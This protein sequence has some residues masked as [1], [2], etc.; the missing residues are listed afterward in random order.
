MKNRKGGSLL[1][2]FLH[3]MQMI[4]KDYPYAPVVIFLYSLSG[5]AIPYW[6]LYYSARILSALL[7]GIY[8][9]AIIQ[10]ILLIGGTVVWGIMFKVAQTYKHIYQWTLDE[11]LSNQ[12]TD[13]AFLMEYDVFES[14]ESMDRLHTIYNK[15]AYNGGMNGIWWGINECAKEAF[16]TLFASIFFI[17]LIWMDMQN[18]SATNMLIVVVLLLLVAFVIFCVISTRINYDRYEKIK[19]QN[20]HMDAMIDYLETVSTEIGKK[21][22][23]MLNNAQG[24]IE[25]YLKRNEAIQN[26][27]S[28]TRHAARY[29]FIYTLFANIYTA[30]CYIYVGIRAIQKI[31]PVSDV[32]LYAGSM[33]RF[34]LH[35]TELIDRY[36]ELAYQLQ[37]LNGY[38]DYIHQPPMH[39]T[40]TLPIEK[41]KDNDYELEFRN[42]SFRYPGSDPYVLKDI[43]LKF[44]VGQKLALVGRNGA[45]KTT[46]VKLLCRL[47]EPTEGE[48]LLNGISIWKYDYAEYTRIFAP[49]FQD[50]KL[51][52]L[53]VA[54]N[55]ASSTEYDESRIQ[56][57]L[58]KAG[59]WDRVQQMKDGIHTQLY[60]NNGD[61]VEISGGEAQKLAIA[62]AW[63]KDAPF[64]I[65]DEPT[66]ALDPLAE[67]EIYEN[68]NSLIENKT[69]IYIS[70]R[71][72]SCK[73]CDSIVV[74]KDGEITEQGTHTEL[75]SRNGEYA[76]LYNAQAAYYN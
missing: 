68:F 1:K 41:R 33:Q 54:E 29:N 20:M 70:H 5:A 47:Y 3:C 18:P 38:Y 12:M 58:E 4:R 42:V 15:V 44:N 75:L 40:G 61:G 36:T 35:L 59:I 27:D 76:A 19:T 26:Y 16:E 72:S 10:T 11:S 63:Y 56:K 73:F 28:W 23:L 55:I 51:F 50:F 43:N 66:A 22:D 39:Y 31:L 53:P 32:L 46:I 57:A 62:R 74:M 64:I 13:K 21:K 48:I 45:G 60:H 6:S 17:R 24:M 25:K 65:L 67:A 9:N 30:V 52:S 34:S 49:V 37:F 71:M 69:A 2:N 14:T 7:E 8:K